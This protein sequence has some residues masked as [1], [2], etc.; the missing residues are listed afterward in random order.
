MRTFLFSLV[1]GVSMVAQPSTAIAADDTQHDHSSHDTHEGA[2]SG[3]IQVV[4]ES[5]LDLQVPKLH[6]DKTSCC[7]TVGGALA[8]TDGVTNVDVSVPNKS[9]RVTFDPSKTNHEA[10]LAALKAAGI[11]ANKAPAAEKN[12]EEKKDSTPDASS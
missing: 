8:E 9:A 7:P 1:L 11:E 3:K 2:S 4:F 5:S 12:T 6:C 10:I